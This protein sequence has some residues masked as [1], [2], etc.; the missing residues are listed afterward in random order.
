VIDATI[1]TT[2]SRMRLLRL[3][4]AVNPFGIALLKVTDG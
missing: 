2:S 4:R 1:V 3:A